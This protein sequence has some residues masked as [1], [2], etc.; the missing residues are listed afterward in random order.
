MSIHVEPVA[1]QKSP[2]TSEPEKT[3]FVKERRLQ[4]SSFEEVHYS[5]VLKI[6]FRSL[7]L[8][9]A[10]L[11]G[12]MQGALQVEGKDSIGS[13]VKGESKSTTTKSPDEEA[14]DH[15]PVKRHLLVA[16]VILG[17]VPKLLEYFHNTSLHVLWCLFKKYILIHNHTQH[18]LILLVSL[19][20]AVQCK[21]TLRQFYSKR[22]M[23]RFV[24]PSLAMCTRG[25]DGDG[26][27]AS[28]GR[29]KWNWRLLPYLECIEAHVGRQHSSLHLHP[30]Q[31]RI[32]SEY[33]A[34]IKAQTDIAPPEQVGALA[35][36]L[37][38]PIDWKIVSI[39]ENAQGFDWA[40]FQLLALSLRLQNHRVGAGRASENVQ[41]YLKILLKDFRSFAEIE[42]KMGSFFDGHKSQLETLKNAHFLRC[43]GLFRH[44]RFFNRISDC[45]G[46]DD[47]HLNC[48]LCA[49]IKQA[50]RNSTRPASGGRPLGGGSDGFEIASFLVF[51]QLK[52]RLL[53][54]LMTRSVAYSALFELVHGLFQILSQQK[55]AAMAKMGVVS[56]FLELLAWRRFPGEDKD[57][58]QDLFLNSSAVFQILAKSNMTLLLVEE[59]I[60]FAAAQDMAIFK[61]MW[62][63]K[64]YTAEP[65]R[66]SSP[67]KAFTYFDS[68][69]RLSESFD[70]DEPE[71]RASAGDLGG[72]TLDELFFRTQNIFEEVGKQQVLTSK[73]KGL[74]L[75]SSKQLRRGESSTRA[76][77]SSLFE[78]KIR[79]ND[80]VLN[81][82]NSFEY[83]EVII[84][85]HIINVL[86]KKFADHTVLQETPPG[87][88]SDRRELASYSERMTVYEAMECLMGQYTVHVSEGDG[89]ALSKQQLNLDY[90]AHFVELVLGL[91]R[92]S[93]SPSEEEAHSEHIENVARI[94]LTLLAELDKKMTSILETKIILPKPPKKTKKRKKK[95]PETAPAK[96]SIKTVDLVTL[97]LCHKLVQ[98][99]AAFIREVVD[100]RPTVLAR[101][102]DRCAP[103]CFE[104]LLC[105]YQKLPN[106]G[107]IL[108]FQDIL[109]R[110]LNQ[111]ASMRRCL[112][113]NESLS[114]LK[115]HN[116]E[117]ARRF[118]SKLAFVW[119]HESVKASG[120]RHQNQPRVA[121]ASSVNL[122]A[123]FRLD[124][125]LKSIQFLFLQSDRPRT[126]DFGDGFA[127][128]ELS[129]ALFDG[130][131]RKLDSAAEAEADEQRALDL[132]QGVGVSPER[133]LQSFLFD[134]RMGCLSIECRRVTSNGRPAERGA[135]RLRGAR[136]RAFLQKCVHIRQV[137]ARARGRA[138]REQA[139]LP[140]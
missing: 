140:T 40:S 117:V 22:M 15:A 46:R 109:L 4:P 111:R 42:T 33:L 62:R 63:K 129:F 32:Y 68:E 24:V 105:L 93:R 56:L 74:Y 39:I 83:S 54:R 75:P 27:K 120:P 89:F 1:K 44:L 116:L 12:S 29:V 77:P 6:V 90:L 126:H 41:Y 31:Y 127:I 49:R 78:N 85:E 2:V 18:V 125:N 112:F 124:W 25:A 45:P 122:D 66:T 103:D 99:A 53:G 131:N 108:N 37:S 10:G 73:S 48:L 133:S 64:F 14:P 87:D 28:P 132:L 98:K 9:V 80:L 35:E 58:D 100:S 119:G 34:H 36:S 60:E 113:S 134:L 13:K 20:L 19:S 8:H 16:L 121:L 92:V 30:E 138:A 139:P 67:K 137:L 84:N 110:L 23:R 11:T 82:R 5:L 43:F 57:K 21:R 115:K 94:L 81:N 38:A 3:H 50:I 70:S 104:R 76:K 52:E 59:V 88:A 51:S 107:D 96:P 86:R 65:A 55:S 101:M 136:I 72:G 130:L 114:Q 69:A 26:R 128:F 97:G 102:L 106:L 17:K 61:Q 91:R 118:A 95:A 123:L 7:G 71:A 47:M 79:Y 135:S